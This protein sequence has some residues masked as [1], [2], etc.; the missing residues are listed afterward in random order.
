MSDITVVTPTFPAR[1]GHLDRC[2]ASVESQTLPAAHAL[3][4]DDEGIGAARARQ[5]AFQTVTTEWTAFLDDDDWL[6]PNHLELLKAWADETEADLVYPAFNCNA[7]WAVLD[8]YHFRAFDA[9]LE[10][11]LRNGDPRTGVQNFI[12]ITVLVKTELVQR[13]GGIPFP[14]ADQNLACTGEDHMLWIKLLDA[15]AAFAHLPV[16][17]WTYNHHQ[18]DAAKN[19]SGRPWKQVIQ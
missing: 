16:R 8:P 10:S 18:W 12:P 11:V 7:D 3:F 1:A 13:V 15:G 5:K 9:E 4:L 6:E 2:M 14:P 17:T 19:T